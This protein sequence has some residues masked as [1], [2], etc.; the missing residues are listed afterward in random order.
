MKFRKIVLKNWRN[1]REEEVKVGD[2]LLIFGGNASGKSNFLDAFRFLRDISSQGGGLQKAVLCRGGMRNVRNFYVRQ[3]D[4]EVHVEMEDEFGKQW[5]YEIVFNQAQK[6]KEVVVVREYVSCDGETL[7]DR[8][9]EE[10]RKDPA[11]LSASFL[12]F[13]V[14]NKDFRVIPEFFSSIQ[15]AGNFLWE[16]ET[17]PVETL[18]SDLK[19]IE[20]FLRSVLDLNI[21]LDA[22]E[23]YGHT[24]ILFRVGRRKVREED[25]SDGTFR[26]MGLFWHAL[27]ARETL[28]IEELER[29]FSRRIV[30]QLPR[31]LRWGNPDLQVLATTYSPEVIEVF[32]PCR[33][34]NLLRGKKESR[35]IELMTY[36][37]G[38]ALANAEE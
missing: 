20:E 6:Q 8:P 2:H 16:M 22:K 23:E 1:F 18:I 29:N 7:L 4:V 37:V 10:D 24:S 15:V 25:I 19:L 27:H 31:I 28:L 30:L 3:E 35:V 14:A 26:L 33:A 13:T 5:T 32:N 11:R 36:M 38:V 12:N 34:I 17:T 9:N 21:T